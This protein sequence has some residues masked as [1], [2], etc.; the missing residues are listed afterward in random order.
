MNISNGR[1]KFINI[2]VRQQLAKPSKAQA[3]LER[4]HPD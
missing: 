2:F 3:L 4:W 1:M